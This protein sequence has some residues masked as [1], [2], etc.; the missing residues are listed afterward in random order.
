MLLLFNFFSAQKDRNSAQV[1]LLLLSLLIIFIVNSGC[2]TTWGTAV[3]APYARND[4]FRRGEVEYLRGNYPEAQYCFYNY[5]EQQT[6]PAAIAE[7]LYWQGMCFLARKDFKKAADHFERA[8]SQ[9]AG[10]KWVLTYSLC[11]L[12]TAYMGTAKYEDASKAL[13]KAIET[14]EDEIQKDEIFFR[15]GV[16]YQR[17]S[18]WDNAEKYFMLVLTE[19]PDSRIVQ[20]A[21]ERLEYGKDRFFSIQIGAYENRQ[22]AE[23]KVSE[24]KNI[25][26]EAYIREVTREGKKIQCVRI[27]KYSDWSNANMELHRLRGIERIDD[28][29]VVP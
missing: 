6:N 21:E 8:L 10:E 23:K 11:G 16:C 14:G 13:L 27:G 28:A 24:L 9:N 4:E 7:G 25:G 20:Q 29:I 15:L 3:V 1:L 22:T 12:G 19:T 5:T 17:I 2:T 26:Q 18:Q